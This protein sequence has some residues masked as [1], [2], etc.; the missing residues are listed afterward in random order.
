MMK[1]IQHSTTKKEL[2]LQQGTIKLGFSTTQMLVCISYDV[3]KIKNHYNRN[4]NIY[5]WSK[6][7]F[8]SLYTMLKLFKTSSPQKLFDYDSVTL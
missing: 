3:M 7:L 8:S 5:V 6:M 4:L 1:E 2:C